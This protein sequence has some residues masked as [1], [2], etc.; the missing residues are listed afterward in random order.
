MVRISLTPIIDVVFILLIFFMLATNFQSFNQTDIK[1]SN[2]EAST[3]Q[4]DK[5]IYL[6]ELNKEGELKLNKARMSQKSIKNKILDSKKN[7][8]EYI[9]VIK[10]AKDTEIQDILNVIADFKKN[11]IKEITIGIS[12]NDLDE[13]Y[14]NEKKSVDM[15][16][17]EKL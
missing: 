4:S 8:E 16:L 11:D 5:R 7:D 6:V 13:N 1:L 15:P 17:L 14:E 12:K 2:E 9:V 10:G 3:S